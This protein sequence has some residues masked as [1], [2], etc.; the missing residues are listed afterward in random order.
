MAAYASTTT[1]DHPT[2]MRLASNNFKLLSGQCDITN[3][4]QTGAEITGITKF[5]GADA[6]RVISDGFS[7]NGYMIRW[8][9][10][11][12]CFH[13]FYPTKAITPAGSVSAPTFTGTANAGTAGTIDD[14]DN[15][16]A[17]G[18]ALYVL[19][20]AAAQ[21]VPP[22]LTV[23]ASAT[24]LIKD[25]DT[26][27]T[28]GVIVYVVVD[29]PSWSATYQLGHFEFVSPTNANGT[30]T[31]GN[32]AATLNLF[33]DDAAASNGV[34]VR[35]VAA[36]AGLEATTGASKDIIVVTSSGKYV[37]VNH[38]TTGSTPTVYFDED[39]AN[40]YERLQAVVV[41]NADEPYALLV[42]LASTENP[43]VAL[44][45]GSIGRLA[46]IVTVGPKPFSYIVG[47]A[48][49]EITV[50][51]RPD[52]ASIP[53]AVALYV[54]A[55]GAGF[56][57]ANFGK[58]DVFVPTSTGEFIKVAYAA[59]PAGVQVYGY[60]EGATADLTILGVIAD[61]AD[62]TFSTEAAVGWKR[63]TPAGSNSAP[64]LTGTPV[65]A[66]AGTEVANDVA[67]GVVNFLAF[68]V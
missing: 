15:A 8:N 11:D 47:V 66:Q 62:E 51:S 17:L 9:R 40:T 46:N 19:P 33:D 63:D 22:V 4:N 13:A 55:A 29:D 34:A 45:Q 53:G 58:E 41:D 54:Q 44:S 38:A 32:G 36:G 5:F 67:V 10:T 18:H 59:S 24:G 35:A 6:P 64:T 23:E 3:Y 57:A 30:C 37:H 2:A 26:A 31:I 65:T 12:K 25:S 56:N 60:P 21:F 28:D 43:G 20:A 49:P 16:A 39:A 68:G 48:G 7:T 50:A 14:N 42:D 1:L 27:A 52:I 61:N